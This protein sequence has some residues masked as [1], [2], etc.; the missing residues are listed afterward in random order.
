MPP[1]DLESAVGLRRLGE[2][3]VHPFLVGVDRDTADRQTAEG[4]LPQYLP[5]REGQSGLDLGAEGFRQ[6][7]RELV[8]DVGEDLLAPARPI[9][10]SRVRATRHPIKKA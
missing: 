9:Q 5:F 8:G 2:D 6:V 4:R 10:E 1:D 3:E 7:G